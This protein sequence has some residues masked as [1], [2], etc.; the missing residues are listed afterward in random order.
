MDE[1]KGL[2]SPI[3]G[4]IRAVRRNISS[5][6]LV[7]RR[8][9]QPQ[10][11]D[12]ITTNLLT[13]QSLQLRNVSRQLELIST[14][15]T[16]ISSSLA[17]VRESLAL[18]QQLENQREQARQNRER[19]LAE[20]G[21][22]EG[23][24]SELEKKIQFALQSPLKRVAA[25]AQG[26]LFSFQKFFL[27]LA[28]GWLTNVGI[29][30]INALVTGNTEQINKL[31]RKF[32]IGLVA[33]GATITTFNVGL[34][35]LFTSLTNFIGSVSR[36]VFGGVIRTTLAGFRLLLKNV[37]IR[38]GLAKG[39]GFFSTTAGAATAGAGGAVVAGSVTTSID[40]ALTKL[41]DDIGSGKGSTG[42][43]VPKKFGD[44]IPDKIKIEGQKT[45]KLDATKNPVKKFFSNR[46]KSFSQSKP[47]KN[48]IDAAKSTFP[49]TAVKEGGKAASKGVFGKL[50]G[51]GKGLFGKLGGG[52]FSFILDLLSGESVDNAIAGAAGFSAGSAIGS[53]IGAGIMGLVLGIPTGGAAAPLGVKAGAVIGGIIGGFLGGD[54]MKNFY[55]GVKNFLGIG[56]NTK[57][58]TTQL[59]FDDM[60]LIPISELDDE[61]RKNLDFIEPVKKSEMD[62]READNNSISVIP[63]NDDS[64]VASGDNNIVGQAKKS[65]ALPSIPFNLGNP[66]TIHSV[67]LMGVA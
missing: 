16:G 5:S 40:N 29:D 46:F 27:F 6:M 19:I 17:G 2:V 24:E 4:G 41:A 44:T 47:V 55:K 26:V 8:Q 37:A 35:L 25:K 57:E 9:N 60:T 64:L 11:P 3:S 15:M 12:P 63:T 66:H 53:A 1:E 34:K 58:E 28:G 43:D 59:T 54:F 32:A 22:R 20:Q 45:P 62:L 49:K 18:S 21:L 13:T 39:V 61:E 31:K 7:S 36:V 14:T 50:L 38:A 52:L 56:K 67:M 42:R 30:L 51:A 65:A 48:F 33:I 10:K 23:K